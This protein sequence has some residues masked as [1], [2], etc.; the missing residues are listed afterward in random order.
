MHASGLQ[1]CLIVHFL[2]C[3][4]FSDT[5]NYPESAKNHSS[6]YANALKSRKRLQSVF[7]FI[8]QI[9]LKLAEI[10]FSGIFRSR[11]SYI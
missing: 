4:T 2:F 5:Q 3:I 8:I 9:L 1:I 7:V 6:V 11:A 10:F